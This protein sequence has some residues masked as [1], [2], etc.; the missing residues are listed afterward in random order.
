MKKSI[1]AKILILVLCLSLVLCGC[2]LDTTTSDDPTEAPTAAPTDNQNNDPTSGNNDPEDPDPQDP[3]DPENPGDN[4]SALGNILEEIFGGSIDQGALEEALQCGKV[5]I[6]MGDMI[7]NVL[8][9]DPVNL[10]LVDQLQLNVDGQELN[11]QLY[12]NEHDL[13]VALPEVLPETYGISFDTLAEDLPNSAIWNLMGITYEDFMTQLSASLDEMLQSMDGIIQSMDE[14]ENMLNDMEGYLESFTEALTEAMENVEQTST[15]GQVDIYGQTVDA[16]IIT[17]SVDN[18]A[19]E[20]MTNI[21]LDWCA[22]NG[23]GLAGLLGDGEVTGQTIADAIAD[24]KTQVS[25]FFDSADLEA[26]LVMNFNPDTG[27]LM[28][29][30]G[31]F[32]GT[33]EGEEGGIYMNLTL[34]VDPTQSN[35]YSFKLYDSNNDGITVSFSYETVATTTTYTL[36][37]SEIVAGDAASAMILS[38]SYDT[39]S[40]KYAFSMNIDGSVNSIN[41]IFKLTEDIFEFSIDSISEDGEVTVVDLRVV[42]ETIS[43]SEIP[44][45]PAYKNLLQMSEL[46]LSSLLLLLQGSMG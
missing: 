25:A 39:A 16:I 43:S 35:L 22:E 7:S 21:L 3:E 32:E 34:G 6:T 11:A 40:Y 18:A 17:Y 30:D 37:C 41:G 38:L 42:A 19:M 31:A 33:V 9:V 45:A 10:K 29:I 20:N 1:F 12:L 46:E 15:T 36:A 23:D 44:N 14:L 26:R 28:S 8:Y 4:S 2:G 27:Y 13:V 24:A 5:T